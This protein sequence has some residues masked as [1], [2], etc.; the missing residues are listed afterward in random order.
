[1]DYYFNNKM[2]DGKDILWGFL[3]PELNLSNSFV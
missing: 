2:T 1:M 3:C